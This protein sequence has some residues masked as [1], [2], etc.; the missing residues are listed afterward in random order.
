ME[1]PAQRL[2]NFHLVAAK[3][4]RHSLAILICNIRKNL[5]PP[6]LRPRPI[7]DQSGTGVTVCRS[8]DRH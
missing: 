5:K 1:D 4:W 3:G 8:S 7:R 6:D 2:V